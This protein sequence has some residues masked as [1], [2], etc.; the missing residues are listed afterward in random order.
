M[1]VA[2]TTAVIGMR[3]ISNQATAIRVV[4]LCTYFWR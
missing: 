1:E 4:L 2:A 3:V